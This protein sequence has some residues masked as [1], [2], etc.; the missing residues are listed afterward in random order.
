MA[1]RYRKRK[2]VRKRTKRRMSKRPK[3]TYDGVV[4]RELKSTHDVGIDAIGQ[5]V[6]R[7]FWGRGAGPALAG[8]DMV[9]SGNAEHVRFKDNFGEY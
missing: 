7:F 8:A 2:S 4:S 1:K 9:M 5:G 6:F 3:R